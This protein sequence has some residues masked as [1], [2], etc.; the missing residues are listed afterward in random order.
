MRNAAAMVAMAI[1]AWLATGATL[2]SAQTDDPAARLAA[3]KS[4]LAAI[5]NRS[6]RLS[7]LNQIENLQRSFGYY[8]DK[9]LWEEVLDLL[10]DDASLEI[11]SSGVFVGK[12]SI[13]EYLFAISGGQPGPLEGELY[14]HLQLQ[15]IVTIS[16]DGDSAK[17]RWRALIMTGTSGSGSGGAW[18][19]GPYEN[20]YRKQDGTWKISKLH[21]YGTFIVPYEGG[22]LDVDPEDFARYS[23]PEGAEPDLPSSVDYEPY[24]AAFTPPYHFENP[25]RSD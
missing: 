22:W 6:D 24:P 18:G 12:D 4:R 23:S 7:D 19:E 25:G 21:W 20:E 3:V 11:G 2:S 15:P 5:E 1:S 8:Y 13:R 9:M 10:T 16:D 17:G 14:E